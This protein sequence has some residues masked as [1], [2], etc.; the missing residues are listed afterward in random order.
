MKSEADV[1]NVLGLSRPRAIRLWTSLALPFC[2][3]SLLLLAASLSIPARSQTASGLSNAA[4]QAQVLTEDSLATP[5]VQGTS[6]AQP[7]LGSPDWVQI[8]VG[9]ASLR[10]GSG[11]RLLQT[12]GRPASAAKARNSSL[13][14]APGV[15]WI[16]NA[17]DSDSFSQTSH[18]AL[19]P[20]GTSIAR[21]R[22]LPQVVDPNDCTEPSVGSNAP[23]DGPLLLVNPSPSLPTQRE[24]IAIEDSRIIAGSQ[25]K[26]STNSSA[27]RDRGYR[28]PTTYLISPTDGDISLLMTKESGRRITLPFLPTISSKGTLSYSLLSPQPT[29]G[30]NAS[31]S[32]IVDVSIYS[33]TPGKSAEDTHSNSGERANQVNSTTLERERDRMIGYESNKLRSEEKL[34]T[35]EA[36]TQSIDLHEYEK[37][38]QLCQKVTEAQE[39]LGAAEGNSGASGIGVFGGHEDTDLLRLGL[40]CGQFLAMNR[41]TAIERMRKHKGLK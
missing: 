37:L 11:E 10:R 19:L 39:A 26:E 6:L 30:D 8:G 16:Q 25:W 41:S 29:G 5:A 22:R 18:R 31:V 32:P 7:A 4:G 15:G 21:E 23:S 24:G 14:F 2:S 38:K 9:T 28:R 3:G 17:P 35:T 40:S 27:P 20:G 13:C 1:S 34:T 36:P 12:S 33:F